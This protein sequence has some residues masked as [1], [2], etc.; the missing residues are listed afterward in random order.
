[1]SRVYWIVAFAVALV[2]FRRYV[3]NEAPAR[4]GAFCSSRRCT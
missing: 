1:M 2:V 4:A 3:V